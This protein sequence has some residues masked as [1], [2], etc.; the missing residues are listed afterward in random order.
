MIGSFTW[1][2]VTAF[3]YLRFILGCIICVVPA[4]VHVLS[5]KPLRTYHDIWK[6]LSKLPL[7]KYVVSGIAAFVA[8]YTA[9]IAPVIENLTINTCEA[10]ISDYPWLRNPFG[11][12]H[13]I[14]LANLGEFAT[15]LSVLSLLQQDKYR[16]LR[17]IPISIECEFIKKARGR[18]LAKG[19]AIIEV[20]FC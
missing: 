19:I 8:P 2:F 14:A 15:G 9:S 18:V 3:Q 7:G 13:A 4:T 10:S 16:H 1:P 11:S 6:F 5:G 20:N 17:G 12:I